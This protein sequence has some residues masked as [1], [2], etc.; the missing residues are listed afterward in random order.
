M[1]CIVCGSNDGSVLGFD[2]LT[3]RRTWCTPKI[4]DN[5]IT[6][7]LLLP[8]QQAVAAGSSGSVVVQRVPTSMG[9]RGFAAILAIALLIF[10]LLLALLL[11]TGERVLEML[12]EGSHHFS[13]LVLD[14]I[15]SFL[16]GEIL[17]VL[18]SVGRSVG[19]TATSHLK[20][21]L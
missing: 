6:S 15:A 3:F 18:R 1:G 17:D 8:A 12:P 21:L 7:L 10:A 5:P 16:P 14:N 2:A 13:Q 11:I 19:I 9:R 20:V 4:H